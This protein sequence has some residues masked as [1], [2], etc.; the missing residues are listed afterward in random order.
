MFQFRKYPFG[1]LAFLYRPLCPIQSTS[2][3]RGLTRIVANNNTGVIPDL[4]YETVGPTVNVLVVS[5]ELR[6]HIS[7]ALKTSLTAHDGS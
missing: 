3:L 7:K 1:S 4:F 6:T 5:G 2:L